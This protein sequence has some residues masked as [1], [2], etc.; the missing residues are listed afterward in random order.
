VLVAGSGP[1][2]RNWC[3]PLLP[4]VNGSGRLL[5]EAFAEADMASLRYD[6]RAAGPHAAKSAA[7]LFG[8]LSMLSHLEELAAAVGVLAG[9]EGVD[10]S[11]IGA[12]GNSEGALHV[13]HYVTSRQ[14]VPFT[15]V[16][17]AAPPG[18]SVGDVLL[19]QLG[20]QAARVPRG[21][22]L[23]GAVEAVVAR[24]AAGRPMDLDPQL[25]DS[26]SG[27]LA[28][29]EAPASLPLARELFSDNAAMY[30]GKSKFLR[31]SSSA[32]RT[33]KSTSRRTEDPLN[34]RQR[35]TTS[36]PS[37]T[38]R[39]Q[40][41]SSKRTSGRQPRRLQPLSA[42]TTRTTRASTPRLSRSF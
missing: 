28:S 42:A 29:F 11:R 7:A 13:L 21:A 20:A 24:Y 33:A 14:D 26:V 12:L 9:H 3:S 38:P 25:P 27:L 32:A 40:T 4:G 31:S 23:M 8:R 2:D 18:R 37:P 41:T 36:S 39:T 16:V 1:T 10:A 30:L 34:K 17:L 6:K 35:A 22:E 15:G 19:A 5:A